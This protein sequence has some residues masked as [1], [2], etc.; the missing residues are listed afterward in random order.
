VPTLVAALHRLGRGDQVVQPSPELGHAANYLYMLQGEPPSTERARALEQYLVSTID[1]GLN[2]STFTARVVASAGADLGSAVIA[3]LGA[4]SGPLHGGAPSRALDMVDEI[5]SAE[6]ADDWIRGTL[7][8]GGR[9]MG[10]GHPAYRTE[11]PRSRMLKELAESLDAPNI[12]LGEHVEERALALLRELR[13]GREIH[14]NVEFYAAFVLAGVG[15]PRSLFTP[16][17]AVSRVIG[18][19][20]HVLEQVRDNAIIGPSARYVGPRP[21]VAAGV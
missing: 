16:T 14:T 11:D 1:H 9:L 19:T 12:E 17:F 15:V 20:A 8:R 5:G 18:W 6:R 4:L 3:A 2:A 21:R 10:F 13:P 7:E